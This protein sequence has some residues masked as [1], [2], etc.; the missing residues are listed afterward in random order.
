MFLKLSRFFLYSAAL[1]VVVVMTTTFFPFIGAKYYFFRIAVELSLVALVLWWAF[2]APDGVLDK[3]FREI[4][5][6]P[7]FLAVSAFVLAYL[8]ATVFALDPHAAFWSNYER[9]EGGFQMIHYYAFFVLLIMLFDTEKDWVKL[10]KISTAAAVLMVLYGLGGN[11]K[12]EGIPGLRFLGPYSGGVSPQT[13]W[14]KLTQGRFQ[15]SLGNPAYVAP[16]LMFSIFY[17]LYVWQSGRSAVGKLARGRTWLY[18]GLAAIFFFFFVLSQTRGAFLGL[19]VAAFSFFIFLALRDARAR[20]KVLA[21]LAALAV[22][23]GLLFAFRHEPLIQRLP[24][25]RLLDISLSDQ[26]AQTRFWTWGSAWRG[27]KERPIFGWGPENFTAV[28][29]KHFDPR[30]Y[31]PGKS[32]ETWFDRAHS[33]FFDYLAETGLVG[34][35]SYI[36]IFVLFYLAFFREFILKQEAH[37]AVIRDPLKQALLF[38]LPIAYLVQ[39]LALFDVLP[40]YLNVFIF[41]A[42]ASFVFKDARRLSLFAKKESQP[43]HQP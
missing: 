25:S 13:F 7:L 21:V 32:T 34:L 26:T 6:R 28:F 40:I 2:E 33:V 3:R 29:D 24:G 43:H 42:F 36:S 17:V 12:L 8:L 38:A 41:I 20:A 22:F 14:E 23:G 18:L 31:V 11:F 30:H 10:F 4:S 19:V 39:G 16:Y 35:A 9:G 15:G 37:H 27:F 5:G 1:S